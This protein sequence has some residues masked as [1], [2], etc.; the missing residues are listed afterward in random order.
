MWARLLRRPCRAGES[1]E[2]KG[3][4]ELATELEP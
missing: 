4:V 1:G 2:I 3:I